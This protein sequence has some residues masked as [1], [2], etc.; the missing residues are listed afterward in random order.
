MKKFLKK[1]F[2]WDSPAQGVFFA[3]TLLGIGPY[4][5]MSVLVDHSVLYIFYGTPSVCM[6]GNTEAEIGFLVIKASF[7]IFL[8][9][10]MFLTFRFYH[11]RSCESGFDFHKYILRFGLPVL[12]LIGGWSCFMWDLSSRW[13]PILLF[14]FF[15]ILLPLAFCGRHWKIALWNIFCGGVSAGLTLFLLFCARGI[16]SEES[17]VSPVRHRID[18]FLSAGQFFGVSLPAVLGVC[19]LVILFFFLAWYF[20]T[21][22]LLAAQGKVSLRAVFGKGT[23]LLWILSGIV[24]LIFLV[25]ALTSMREVSQ[26]TALLEKRFGRPLSFEEKSKAYYG[27][28]RPDK[29]FWRRAFE[30]SRKYEVDMPEAFPVS[31]PFKYLSEAD[32]NLLRAKLKEAGKVSAEWE[33]LFSAPIPP[34]EREYVFEKMFNTDLKNL[35]LMTQFCRMEFW[36]L[37]FALA[38][39]DTQTALVI[40]RRVEKVQNGL[41]RENDFTGLSVWMRYGT[42]RLTEVKMLLESGRLTVAELETIAGSLERMEKQIPAMFEHVH[43]GN[44]V[45]EL[46][47]LRILSDGIIS[48]SDKIERVLFFPLGAFR[49]FFPQLWWYGLQLK[50]IVVNGIGETAFD[51]FDLSRGCE[52]LPIV[53]HAITGMQSLVHNFRHYIAELRAVQVLVCAERYKL[54]HDRYPD[55]MENLPLDPYNGKPLNYRVG[56]CRVENAK[57]VW[58]T[59]TNDSE[60]FFLGGVVDTETVVPAVQ[61]WSVG[62]DRKDS[63]GLPTGKTDKRNEYSDDIHVIRRLKP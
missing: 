2:F 41:L 60:K 53:I 46:G 25:L 17:L 33:T 55:R 31:E 35:N 20:L 54:E 9:Y 12:L 45:F 10:Y 50:L 58:N 40:W 22:R 39:G 23:V 47:V 42:L 3:L 24:Y 21:A 56:E 29:D 15:F 26:K 11:L 13:I 48:R 49:F 30:L 59:V 32:A 43:F 57:I 8:I 16:D 28:A 52:K 61:V 44:S 19:G 51:K 5:I 1:L 18:L 34:C 14:G 36:K 27:N 38:D 63:G 7:W 37:Y 6:C 4:I 62:A